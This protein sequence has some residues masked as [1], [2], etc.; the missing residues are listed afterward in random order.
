MVR[1]RTTLGYG[2]IPIAALIAVG[3]KPGRPTPAEDQP[4]QTAPAPNVP[5]SGHSDVV[6]DLQ[7]ELARTVGE[8]DTQMPNI[9]Y[10]GSEVIRSGYAESWS[11]QSAVG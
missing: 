8:R 7:L 2:K 4:Q 3:L 1:T 11:G 6:H 5:E 9:R 10:L